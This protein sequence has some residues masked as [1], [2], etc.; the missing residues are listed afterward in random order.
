MAGFIDLA[1]A[2]AH[3]RL[4]HEDDDAQ[5]E[6]LIVAAARHIEN[7]TNVAPLEHERTFTFDAFA[8]EL[9]VTCVPVDHDSVT[10]EYV[11]EDGEEQVIANDALRIVDIDGISRVLPIVGQCWPAAMPVRGAVTVTATVGYSVSGAVPESLNHAARLLVGHWYRN[12]EAAI[13]GTIVSEAPQAVRQLLAL[14]RVIF[15]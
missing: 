2:K 13:T 7:S 11:D 10:I 12:R 14:E 1:D 6:R 15:P 8:D 3:L 9:V 5:V 4:L